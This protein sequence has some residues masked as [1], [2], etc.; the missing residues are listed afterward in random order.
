MVFWSDMSR[1][2]GRYAKSL[3]LT[4]RSS[5]TPLVPRRFVITG[6]HQLGARGNMAMF[7]LPVGAKRNTC[8]WAAIASDSIT[9]L[10]ISRLLS[11][12]N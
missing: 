2:L 8:A 11:K 10:C 7:P 3:H 1:S 12:R 9:M 5:R 4:R 6:Q